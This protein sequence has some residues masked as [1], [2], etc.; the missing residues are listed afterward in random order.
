MHFVKGEVHVNVLI[1]GFAAAKKMSFLSFL[2][3]LHQYK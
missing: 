1:G 3:D 2:T